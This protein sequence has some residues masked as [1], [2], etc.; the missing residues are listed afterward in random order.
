M[1]GRRARLSA[2]RLGLRLFSG[3]SLVLLTGCAATTDF[4][5]R[6]VEGEVDATP[7]VASRSGTTPVALEFIHA[8]ENEAN[9]LYY[10]LDGVAG[11]AFAPDGTLLVC[12]EKLGKVYGQDPH[13]LL[14]YEFDN[15]GSRPYRPV[16]AVVDGFKVLV[17]DSAGG[18]IHRFDLNGA[19]LDLRLNLRWVDPGAD[20][21]ATAFALDRDGRL[22][23]VDAGEQQVLLLDTF[24][25]L[26]MR[27]GGPGTLD[28]QFQQP[29]GAAFLPDGSFVVADQGNRRLCTY[30]RSGFFEGIGGGVFAPDNPYVAPQGVDSDRFGN[31]FVA[32]AGAGLIHVL[33]R[34]QNLLFSAGRESA[35]GVR[36]LVRST[37]R[38]DRTTSWP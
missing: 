12:D 5:L 2:W 19:W 38:S 15:P 10:P 4:D 18:S 8:Y 16:D 26:H 29:M 14:W 1:A 30:G 17:L 36:R 25:D 33:D 20:T 27:V 23:I 35:S 6:D 3:W 22:I 9:A 21:R 32:D 13:N 11:C 34:E 7:P 28:D 24:L 37:W 31:L